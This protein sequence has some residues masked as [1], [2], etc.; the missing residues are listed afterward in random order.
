MSIPITWRTVRGGDNAAALALIRQSQQDLANAIQGVGGALQQGVDRYVG[1]QTD[2][3]LHALNQ[4]PDQATRDQMIAEAKT[5]F[6]DTGRVNAANRAII[7]DERGAQVFNNE[8]Q[9]F[10]NQQQMHDFALK[11]RQRQENF[12]NNLMNMSQS[13]NSS[14]LSHL[15]NLEQQALYAGGSPAEIQYIQRLK[16]NAMLNLDTNKLVERDMQ[17]NISDKV[18]ALTKK[19]NDLTSV[20]TSKITQE[21]AQYLSKNHNMPAQDA[22][23]IAEKH[24]V[25]NVPNYKQ[26]NEMAK[27]L[28]QTVDIYNAANLQ[29]TKDQADLRSKYITTNDFGG[30]KQLLVNEMKKNPFYDKTS[31]SSLSDA[32]AAIV[33][34]VEKEFPGNT[35]TAKEKQYRAIQYLIGESEDRSPRWFQWTEWGKS[36]RILDGG[37]H[38]QRLRY[39]D[40]N[41]EEGEAARS[42]ARAI[43]SPL[44][45]R[46]LIN[47]Q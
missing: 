3:F 35:D 22:L 27:N 34:F 16:E 6:L 8:M 24:L 30:R 15:N 10:A 40:D 36:P 44:Y 2:Q 7:S 41:D 31:N 42:A 29:T 25:N 4:A 17:K 19:G 18:N 26:I 21:L 1:N 28:D 13:A 32:A 45:T 43:L 12:R 46:N 38:W 14:D 33:N 47:P 20:D 9:R 11:D 39:L 5:A 23:S 37:G